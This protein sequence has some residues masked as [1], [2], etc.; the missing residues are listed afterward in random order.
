[1]AAPPP[2]PQGILLPRPLC[3]PGRQSPAQLSREPSGCLPRQ[4]PNQSH[5]V[6]LRLCKLWGLGAGAGGRTQ[7]ST[8]SSCSE[9]RGPMVATGFTPYPRM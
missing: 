9:S 3:P 1:M 6:G 4:C 8:L 7:A 2:Q 5:G